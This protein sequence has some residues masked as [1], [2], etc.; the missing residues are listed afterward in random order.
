MEARQTLLK[1]V[2][3][4]CETGLQS[5]FLASDESSYV[6]GTSLIVDGIQSA[7]I[8]CL[9]LFCEW[10][11]MRGNMFLPESFLRSGLEEGFGA[12]VASV[13]ITLAR[14]VTYADV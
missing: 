10:E 9:N 14:G 3:Q 1:R 4:P 8:R 12:A 6:T 2:G 13:F 5:F 7:I 11:A